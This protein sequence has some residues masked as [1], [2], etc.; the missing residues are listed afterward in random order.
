MH[1]TMEWPA[2]RPH[3]G[4]CPSPTAQASML[5]HLAHPGTPHRRSALHAS[6]A[7]LPAQMARSTALLA[8][9]AHMPPP[10]VKSPAKIA[11]RAKWPAMWEVRRARNAQLGPSPSKED[12]AGPVPTT[13]IRRMEC[14]AGHAP[15]A[16]SHRLGLL[17]APPALPGPHSTGWWANVP[18]AP[19]EAT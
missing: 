17:F 19:L 2:W 9:W 5:A 1:P 11:F 12:S 15:R 18:H 4:T 6:P 3:Q 14:N 16:S 7:I 13:A 10:L 8:L